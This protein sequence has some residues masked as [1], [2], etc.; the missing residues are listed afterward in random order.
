MTTPSP[1]AIPPIIATKGSV[2]LL[3]YGKTTLGVVGLLV[4][5]LTTVLIA[6]E[7]G[8]RYRDRATGE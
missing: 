3:W 4:A 7:F 1:L 5:L 6:R 8:Y 2:V